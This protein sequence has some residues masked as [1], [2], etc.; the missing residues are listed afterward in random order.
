MTGKAAGGCWLAERP[1]EAPDGWAAGCELAGGTVCW[2]CCGIVPTGGEI[3]AP[4]SRIVPISGET[5]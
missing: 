1:D 4:C 5:C 3:C 2:A